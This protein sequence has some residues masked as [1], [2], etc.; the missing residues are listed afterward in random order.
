[1]YQVDLI[2][3]EIPKQQE[4]N[5][6][7]MKMKMYP[8]ELKHSNKIEIVKIHTLHLTQGQL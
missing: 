7:G 3:G 6:T 2:R 8:L 4:V 5:K 1:M